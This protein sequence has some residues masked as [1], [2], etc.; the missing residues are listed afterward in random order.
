MEKR[1]QTQKRKRRKKNMPPSIRIGIIITVVVLAAI[2]TGVLM[3]PGL[4]VSEVYCE[5]CNNIKSEDIIAAANIET[6]KSIF[7]VNV[8]KAEREI[9]NNPLVKEVEV[10]RVLPNKICITVVERVPY[11]YIKCGSDYAAV[12]SE[13]K[14]VRLETGEA[15]VKI[16]ENE[17]PKFERDEQ[18]EKESTDANSKKKSEE[19]GESNDDDKSVGEETDEEGVEKSDDTNNSKEE[20]TEQSAGIET[21]GQAE[22]EFLQIPT[23]K[24]I[25]LKSA[26]EKKDANCDDEDKLKNLI[27]LCDALQ[28]AKLLNMTSLIDLSDI[29]NIRMVVENRLEVFIGNLDNI[30]Y[31]AKFLAEVIINKVSAYEVA[32]LDYTGDDVYVRA[33]DDGKTRVKKQAK[34]ND[35]DNGNESKEDEENSENNENNEN[36]KNNEDSEKGTNEED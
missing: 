30:E 4:K 6:G 24:G 33:R 19:T 25:E 16:A 11:A 34:D 32:I 2:F 13:M 15:S 18:K 12:D 31:R 17:I 21:D 35:E 14:I 20:K 36:D 9:E 23:V 29:N 3:A 28:K 10:K 1:P 27:T 26:K 7:L 8:G 22:V 5:G